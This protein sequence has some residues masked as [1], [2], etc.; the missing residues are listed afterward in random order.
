MS[1]AVVA[2]SSEEVLGVVQVPNY[3]MAAHKRATNKIIQVLGKKDWEVLHVKNVTIAD[4]RQTFTVEGLMDGNTKSFCSD[5][6]D[7]RP[8]VERR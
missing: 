3:I 8:H 6:T 2:V 1:Q 4:D 7:F 5:N